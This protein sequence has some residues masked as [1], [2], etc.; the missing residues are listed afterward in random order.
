[1]RDNACGA[2]AEG[3]RR[4]RG[5][6]RRMG[7]T[8]AATDRPHS[9]DEGANGQARPR[10]LR[11]AGDAASLRSARHMVGDALAGA[12]ADVRDAAVLLAGEI[13]TNAVVHGG[14]WFLLQVDTAQD[15]VY[16]EVVD[17][18]GGEP[19]VLHPSSDREHGRGMA[20]V[21]AMASAWGSQQRGSHKVVWFELSLDDPGERSAPRRSIRA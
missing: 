21:D 4:P 20:I 12:A 17:S 14:G 16:V 19:T 6:E 8:T 13:L 9:H 1:M 3:P 15:R 11:M 18:A 2:P 5:N 7:T 10:H